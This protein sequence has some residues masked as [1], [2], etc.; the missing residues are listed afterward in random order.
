MI[1]VKRAILNSER[2]EIMSAS[3]HQK[4]SKHQGLNALFRPRS[5]AFIGVSADP[6]KPAGRPMQYAIKRKYKGKIWPVNPKHKSISNIP[7]YPSVADLPDAPDVAMVLVGPA[8]AE[9]YVRE[10][11]EIGTSAAVIFAGGYS[12]S[13]SAGITRQNELI[14]AAGSMRIL[15]PNTIGMINLID[16]VCLTASAALNLT[17]VQTGSISV[18]SQSGGILGSLMS[19]A[20]SRGIGFANLIAT[21]NESDIEVSDLI[22]FLLDEPSTGVISLYLETLRNPHRFRAVAEKAVEVRKPLIVYKIGKSE[23]GARSVASHTGALAG[24]D[25]VFDALFKQVG[26]LRVKNYSDLI[27][28]PMAFVNG[29]KLQGDRLAILT[30]TGGAGALVADICG[31]AGFLTPA[32]D[33]AT[34]RSLSK[35]MKDDGF[36]PSRNPIDV[37]MA[38]VK[39][40]I[41]S[42]ALS[43]ILKSDSYDAVIPIAGSS[44]ITQPGLIADPVIEQLDSTAKPMVIYASP[45]APDVLKRLNQNKVPAYDRPEA[46]AT[47]L[48][49][50]MILNKLWENPRTEVNSIEAIAESR[51]QKIISSAGISELDELAGRK[52]LLNEVESKKIFHAFSI[53]SVHEIAVNNAEDARTAVEN[54]QP[55]VVVKLLT[56]EYSHKTEFEGVRL[57]VLKKDVR[58]T[59][60]EISMAFQNAT[61]KLPEGF[62]IQEQINDGIEMI[63][64]FVHAPL[65]GHAILLGAGGVL[66]E[67][68]KDNALRVLPI[69][70]SDVESMLEELKISKLLSG[71]R[72]YPAADKQALIASVLHFARMIEHFG[73]RLL[74]AEINPLFVRPEGKGVRAGDGVIVLTDS[75]TVS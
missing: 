73:E 20:D 46:C 3:S 74:E 61:G 45:A 18:I 69:D 30:S 32:P 4:S 67:L 53:P 54:F 23:S 57:G 47:A 52:G 22:D 65:F 21:G 60:L 66:A 44:S 25:R 42:R 75:T 28:I 36:N 7:C 1:A 16:N 14:K 35:I 41:L 63:L 8:L 24:E 71:Y 5:I 12:E 11:A 9:Q 49:S 40:E 2:C 43:C 70:G 26:A 31:S 17:T 15:G 64:G 13:G 59:C 33:A 58:S 62:L 72:G 19:R 68:Y 27:D 56:R 10:L 50:L 37:T 39:P 6:D 29:R 55:P 48:K 38:G 34:I 51:D